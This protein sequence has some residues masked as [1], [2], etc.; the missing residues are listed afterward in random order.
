[1][2][3]VA[4][5]HLG[6]GF[7]VRQQFLAGGRLA[8]LRRQR[9][10]KGRRRADGRRAPDVHLLD[11]RRHVAIVVELDHHDTPAAACAGRSS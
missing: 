5:E 4:P 8:L 7:Q 6:S 2:G 9:H 1:M 3:R 10:A 11:R